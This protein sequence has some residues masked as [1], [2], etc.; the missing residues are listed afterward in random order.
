MLKKARE[1]LT[2]WS[3]APHSRRNLDSLLSAPPAP[4][5][6]LRK[7]LEWLTDLIQ[8]IRSPGMIKSE[9][10]FESGQP[11]A[12]R[13]KIL[14]FIL[15]RNPDWKKNVAI[16]LRSIIRDTTALDLFVNT[17]VPNQQG[18]VAEM[19]ERL[20]YKFLPQAPNYANL[21]SFF[22][23]TFQKEE[24]YL[25]I[26]Q[27]D[28]K[29]FEDLLSLFSYEDDGSDWNSLIADANDAILLLST[30]INGA[31][32]SSPIRSRLNGKHF[33]SLPF[34][35]LPLLA[36]KM[37]ETSDSDQRLVLASQLEKMLD[38]CQLAISEVYTH[39]NEYGVSVN[40]VFILDRMEGQLRRIRSLIELV[41]IH[42]RNP[43][44][45]SQ[46]VANL[47]MENVRAHKV[48]ALF[49][50][51]LA[52]IAKK[53]VERSAETGEHYITRNRAEYLYIL[54]KALGGGF[55]TGITTLVKYL[56]YKLNV[57]VFFAGFFA[58]LNYSI[59]FVS[60]QL[61]GFTLAT[62]QPAMTAPAL[63]AKMHKVNDPEALD[64][65]VDEIIH[66]IRSQFIAVLGNIYAVVPTMLLIAFSWFFIFKQHL[67]SPDT[68][69][70]TMESLSILGGTAPYAAFTG[71]LLWLSSVIA[72]WADNWFVYH[73]LNSAISQNRRFVFVFGE[74]GAKKIALYFRK[75][76]SGFASNISLGF[77]L[78]LIPAIGTFLGLPIDVRHVTL[79]SGALSAAVV[80]M[81]STVFSHSDFWFAV[82]GI[83]V[84]GFLNVTVAF[85]MSMFI[86]IRARRVKTP[87]RRQI[88]KAVVARIKK[89][90]LSLFY[91][92][93]SINPG[94]NSH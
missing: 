92:K 82:V 38:R 72:G 23:Q 51:N 37:T 91:P 33:K 67:L 3:Q 58:S 40:I 75:N 21:A 16:L 26:E 53:I 76:I 9:L 80:T 49:A 87:Q 74:S 86:A 59:S 47:M 84:C 85:S 13:A 43:E 4:E 1:L 83:L 70:H 46:F 60:I 41:L 18:F 81:G 22:S 73:K 5:A 79:S 78:G 77:F 39:L 19:F 8:W 65:L 36:Q 94:S 24:D 62:K 29:V 28:K 54:K 7:R 89:Q 57:S 56:I 31:G 32:L 61:L 50:D 34:F 44:A 68:A 25:W 64:K 66:L 63:A 11:Q 2:K 88:Y 17:G 14:M 10:D 45:V 42:E 55:L 20:H 15:E 27:T 12:I 69:H 93:N 48:R 52:L 6:L 90:P 30:Q 35:E 71:I